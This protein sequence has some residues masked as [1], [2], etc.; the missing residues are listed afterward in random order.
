MGRIDDQVHVYLHPNFLPYLRAAQVLYNLTVQQLKAA[1]VYVDMQNTAIVQELFDRL[2]YHE[3]VTIPVEGSSHCSCCRNILEAEYSFNVICD[4]SFII[5]HTHSK[6]RKCERQ[7][8][9]INY[10]NKPFVLLD[11]RVWFLY[12]AMAELHVLRR[13]HQIRVDHEA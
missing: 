6:P 2:P 3:I 1:Q 9:Q 10:V 12:E 4:R 11:D 8:L 13:A 7:H 5:D